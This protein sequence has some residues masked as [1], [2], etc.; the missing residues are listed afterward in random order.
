MTHLSRAVIPCLAALAT[1][2]AARPAHADGEADAKVERNFAGSIQ[3]DYMALPTKAIGR[4]ISLD[5]A[6]TE[7]SLKVTQDFGDRMSASVKLCVGCHGFE[8]AMAFFDLRVAD[9]LS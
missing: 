6:T 9:E 2:W 7:I 5:A 3:L 8:A 4:E 1:T